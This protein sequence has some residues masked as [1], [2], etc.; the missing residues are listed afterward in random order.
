MAFSVR[1]MRIV[2]REIQRLFGGAPANSIDVWQIEAARL[3]ARAPAGT[4]H[5]APIRTFLTRE[6]FKLQFREIQE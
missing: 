4:P 1:N 2:N 5:K 3:L 6:H